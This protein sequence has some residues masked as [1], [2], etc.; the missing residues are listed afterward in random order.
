MEDRFLGLV[1]DEKVRVRMTLAGV[2]QAKFGLASAA[3]MT[4]GTSGVAAA[5]DKV[6]VRTGC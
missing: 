3:Q 5:P 2:G 6:K 1:N 4:G